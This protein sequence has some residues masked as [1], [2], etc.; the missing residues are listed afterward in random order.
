MAIPQPSVVRFHPI[1]SEVRRAG[2][3]QDHCQPHGRQAKF[4]TDWACQ[5]VSRA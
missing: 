1:F 5:P 4:R 2:R 3:D